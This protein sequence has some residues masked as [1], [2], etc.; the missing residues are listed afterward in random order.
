MSTVLDPASACAELLAHIH[1]LVLEEAVAIDEVEYDAIWLLR[2]QREELTR[3][4]AET[5]ALLAATGEVEPVAARQMR[6][7]MA[8]IAACDQNNQLHL[9]RYLQR[10]ADE[11]T[12]L[13]EGRRAVGGY[14]VPEP[15]TAAYIDRRG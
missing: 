15:T 5:C 9:E 11:L 7:S 2:R 1:S 14:R 3:K 12:H 4:V 6:A 13:S 8:R 10:L